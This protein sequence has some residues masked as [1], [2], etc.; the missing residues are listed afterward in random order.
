MVEGGVPLTPIQ[1]WF[2]EKELPQANHFNQAVLLESKEGVEAGRLEEALRA[3]VE[4]HDALRMR[5]VR[6]ES[7]WAQHNA[8]L[9]KA[10]VLEQVDVSALSEADQDRA[11]AEAVARTQASLDLREGLLLRALWME[12]G[13]GRTSRLLLVVHHLVVD[14]VSWR[15]LLEDLGT[16]YAQRREGRAVELPAKTTSFQAWARKLEA[17][18]RG[19][20]LEKEAA[21]W[22]AQPDE[23]PGLPVD[24][25]GENSVA[26]AR[27]VV[28]GLDAEETRVLLQEVPGAY[29]ATVNEV[30]VGAL[31]RVLTQWTGHSRVRVD[32]EGHGREELFADADVTRTVG[33]FT[34]LY[35]VVLEVPEAGTAGDA[36]RAVRDT[37]RQVPG[38]GVGYGLLRYQGPASVVAK[39]KAAAKAE[40]AFNYLGQFDALATGAGGFSLAKE[41]SGPA[42]GEGGQRGH[43][44]EVNGL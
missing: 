16:A 29:R 25:A 13:A 19:P 6:G 24:T 44:L 30:L 43:V 35:P 9:E 11:L 22:L 39:L 10:L 32:V 33:W 34:S 4:H 36:L 2:F 8:G 5:Y 31:A 7:G 27:G 15:V 41:L 3:L 17:Y 18:A 21:W 26:S 42:M 37:L 20:E 38:K 1:R 40:V 23:V 12:R 28:A 14:G